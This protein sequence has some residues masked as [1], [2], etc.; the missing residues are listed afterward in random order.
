MQCVRVLIVSILIILGGPAA[1]APAGGG[2]V[3]ELPRRAGALGI[4]GT[5]STDE[6]PSFVVDDVIAGSLAEQAGFRAGDRVLRLGGG[7]LSGVGAP[8]AGVRAGEPMELEILGEDGIIRVASFIAPDD[9]EVLEGSVVRYGSV[10]VPDGYRLR[11]IVTEPID[12]PRAVAGRH[13]ALLFVQ[14]IYCSSIDRPRNVDA[15]DTRIVHAMARAGFVTMRVD[16]PGLG[17]SE[18]PDCSSI[19][20]STELAG[21]EAALRQLAAMPSVDPDRIYIFGHSMGG[22]MAPYLSA[23]VSV[24]GSIVYG[25]LVRTW[26]EYQLENSRWQM[27]LA[28]YPDGLVNQA[29]AAEARLNA[30]VLVEKQTFGEAWDRWPELRQVPQGT[31]VGPEHLATRHVRFFHELQDLN[32]AEAWEKSQ[33]AVLAIWGSHDFVCVREDHERIAAIV[34]RR[35]PGTGRFLEL[36]RAGHAFTRHES[37]QAAMS[38][39]GQGEFAEDLPGIFIEWIE[40]LEAG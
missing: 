40:A 28:G 4:R 7:P 10:A 2:A 8:F 17:D 5:W 13:P 22:V 26:F 21:F 15:V 36:D 19:D 20:F 37:I 29:I 18:G 1:I 35:S 31:M 3:D 27:E 9:R 16:K 12:S 23:A 33:G 6:E 38:A 11:T 30:A 39:M 34:D 24:R 14:G 32:L 25:T